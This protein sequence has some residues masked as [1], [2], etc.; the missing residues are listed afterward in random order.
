MFSFWHSE[1][2][3]SSGLSGGVVF[4]SVALADLPLKYQN[5]LEPHTAD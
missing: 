4:Q 2:S 5:R 1:I 3:L